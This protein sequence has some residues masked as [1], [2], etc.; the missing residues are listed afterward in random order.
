MREADDAP[1]YATNF[2]GFVQLSCISMLL[3]QF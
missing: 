3:R 2:L 1:L